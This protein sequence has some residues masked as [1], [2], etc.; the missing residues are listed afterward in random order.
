MSGAESTAD[1]RGLLREVVE[2]PSVSGE[3]AAVAERLLDYFEARGREAYVDEVGN[4]RAPGD[5]GV[6]LTSHMDTV[7]G[8]IPVRE[9]AGELWGRGA[10]DAKGPL[11]AM[12]VAAARTG[13]SFVGVVR[14]ETDARGA[15]HLVETRDPPAAVINGEPSGWDAITLAY[16]GF[17]KGTFAAAT[18]PSRRS[19]SRRSSCR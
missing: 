8:D 1:P 11:C 10:C 4:V 19:A 7:P 3:E 15:H 13:A 5:D 18:R 14:E 2:T 17:V 9:A 12:A 16:R 6:L